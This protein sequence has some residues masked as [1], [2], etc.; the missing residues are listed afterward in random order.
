[1][2]NR[3]EYWKRRYER[4]EQ[5]RIEA[6]QRLSERVDIAAD[7]QQKQIDAL[8]QLLL[9]RTA[10]TNIERDGRTIRL[11]FVRR[12]EVHRLNMYAAMS[13]DLDGARAVLLED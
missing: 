8:E 1:M 4:A 2:T 5:G 6:L 9:K 12:G 7:D 11:T 10:L 3:T 13:F